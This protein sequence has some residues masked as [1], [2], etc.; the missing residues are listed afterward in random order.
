MNAQ[1]FNNLRKAKR[2]EPLIAGVGL[3]LFRTKSYYA[4]LFAG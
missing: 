2:Y 4:V 3:I 1:N